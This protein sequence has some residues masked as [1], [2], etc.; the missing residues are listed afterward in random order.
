MALDAQRQGFQTLQEQECV[1]RRKGCAGI[2]QE[3][4]TD[5]GGEC[6]R[7]NGIDKADAV[8]ARV[9]VCDLAELAGCLPVKLAALD[10][11]AAERVPCPP[12][13]LVAE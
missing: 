6:C 10:N 8:V 12:M 1:E 2:A 9:R 5:V 13:N 3:N 7:T 11:Q 4:R